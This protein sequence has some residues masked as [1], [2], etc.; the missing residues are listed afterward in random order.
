MEIDYYGMLW[1]ASSSGLHQF[2]TKKKLWMENLPENL[3]PYRNDT[4]D[5]RSILIDSSN[6]IWLGTAGNGVLSTN[7]LKTK[8]SQSNNYQ[9]SLDK[10]DTVNTIFKDRNGCL[11]LGTNTGLIKYYPLSSE[12][13]RF[14][15][16]DS[17]P[18]S[19]ASDIIYAI[20][21][22]PS[23]NSHY[24][25]LGTKGGG[26][27]LLDVEQEIVFRHTCESNTLCCLGSNI[28]NT[29]YRVINN[30]YY[31]QSQLVLS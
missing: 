8:V 16:D 9:I 30:V 25:W 19:L 1:I 28:I 4:L 15:R 13:K 24:L 3:L 22:D 20:C 6:I 21:E 26:I 27:N 17:D 7:S 31:F 12:L 5:I 29:I 18:R 10:S 23:E 11:W 14:K 2:D